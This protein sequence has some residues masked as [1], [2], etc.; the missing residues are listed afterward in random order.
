MSTPNTDR[1]YYIDV[2]SLVYCVASCSVIF[3]VNV[4]NILSVEILK[5][6]K[7]QILT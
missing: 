1:L 2:N 6:I 3:I 7:I 5:K 4:L